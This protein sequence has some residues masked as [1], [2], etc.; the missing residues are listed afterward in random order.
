VTA[1]TAPSTHA[2]SETVASIEQNLG[3]AFWIVAAIS[4]LYLFAASA[5]SPL[6]GVYAAQ[7]HFSPITLTVVFGV[8][9][10]TLLVTMLLAGSVS[11]AFGRRPVII[12]ALAVQSVTMLLF[13]LADNV[14]WLYAARLTQ[15]CATGLVTAAVSAALVDLQPSRRPG[16]AAV[17]NATVPPAGLAFGALVSG[18]L[19][20]YAPNPTRFVYWL[21][22]G[23][24]VGMI[25]VLL[26]LVPE[27]VPQRHMP[28]FGVEV[29]VERAL[30]RAFLATVPVLVACWALAGL[31]LSLGPSI[32][33]TMQHSSNKLL[34]GSI[35]FILCGC[36][37]LSGVIAH[38][39]PPRRAMSVGCATLAAG[40]ILTVLS[41]SQDVTALLYIGTVVAGCGFGLGFL[42]AFRTLAGLAMS[43]RRSQLIA[44]IYVV[45]YLSFSIPS[46]VAGVLSAHVGL[47]DT[48]IG[49]GIAVAALALIALPATA[50]H[51]RRC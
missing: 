31:Y 32:V 9:A 39:W 33:L 44:T 29:G 30:V 27:T 25:L 1:S 10:I 28:K 38:A 41:V 40:V 7:W 8:Y 19:V 20:Q 51:C 45:A 23:G 15:G 36:G 17:V 35:V 2:R 24:F 34:G 37:A 18:A 47:H 3:R 14:G 12:T 42:G 6:Y 16:L 26:T 11:D 21:L 49:F 4:F 50:R 48:A 5:P 13:L 46:V 43:E 22:L